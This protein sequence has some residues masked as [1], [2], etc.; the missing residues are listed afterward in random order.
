MQ[1]EAGPYELIRDELPNTIS[2]DKVTLCLMSD[3]SISERHYSKYGGLTNQKSHKLSDIDA[4][5]Q[6]LGSLTD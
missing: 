6:L 4:A 3:H 2:F 5:L 1:I